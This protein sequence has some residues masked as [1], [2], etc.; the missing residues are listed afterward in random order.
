MK[1]CDDC[2]G[3]K[4]IHKYITTLRRTLKGLF[5]VFSIDFTGPFPVPYSGSP[6]FLLVLVEHLTDWRILRVTK[7]ATAHTVLNFME[8]EV[9]H[10]CGLPRVVVGDNSGCI[11]A[12]SM[13]Y[14]IRKTRVKWKPFAAYAPVPDGKD[15]RMFGTIKKNTGRLVQKKP[16]NWHKH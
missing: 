11:T 1:A 12:R 10:T 16:Q 4:P 7:N 5:K 8:E 13:V 2:Q 15:K 3:M 14:F 6:R 9:L